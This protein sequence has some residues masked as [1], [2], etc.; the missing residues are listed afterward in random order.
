MT[1]PKPWSHSA[2]EDFVNCPRSYHEKR[3]LKSIPYVQG[4]EAAYGEVVHKHFED[5]LRDGVALPAE[6][7]VHE[8]YLAN[9]EAL[10]GVGEPERDIAIN[11]RGQSC[12]YWDDDVWYRGK[13]DYIKI[14]GNRARVYDWK[15]GKPHQK[16]K[17]LYEY[18]L[19]T[20]IAYPHV[21]QVYAEYYW[22]KAPQTPTGVTI[23]R[24][25]IPELWAMLLPDLRQY[26][27]AF[28]E[29]IWQPRPSGL[30]NGWC[31]VESCEFWKP[32]RGR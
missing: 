1:Q 6:L 27:Q 32:R 23:G 8:V 19:W 2:L 26:A 21:E 3:V 31:P 17:Q 15:T 12:G 14:N 7:H 11:L 18:I 28:R 30:C 20:F 4:P 22:T 29:D 13:V 10:P 25:R 9:L 5:R 16:L 24:E